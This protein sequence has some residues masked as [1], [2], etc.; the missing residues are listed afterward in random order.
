MAE[1]LFPPGAAAPKNKPKAAKLSAAVRKEMAGRTADTPGGS[2]KTPINTAFRE[3]C[4]KLACLLEHTG[5]ASAKTLRQEH[6]CCEQTG[7]TLRR[8]FY[9]WYE[10]VSK[11]LYAL[12][13]T[14]VTYLEENAQHPLVAH[15]RTMDGTQEVL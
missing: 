4:I 2:T 11:G 8:N 6:A 15:Y 3:R 5:P 10:K 9:G 12:S 1:V 14:G 13:A 7:A